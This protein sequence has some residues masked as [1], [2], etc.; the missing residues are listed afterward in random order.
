MKKAILW[1]LMIALIPIGTFFVCN[2]DF[3]EDKLKSIVYLI[4]GIVSLFISFWSAFKYLKL[5]Y[6]DDN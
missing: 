4:L 5:L 6:T 3:H 1:I 2:L